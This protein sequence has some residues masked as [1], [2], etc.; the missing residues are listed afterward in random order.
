M[1]TKVLQASDVIK[2]IVIISGL[3]YNLSYAD[4]IIKFKHISLEQG[5]S[6]NSVGCIFQDSKG[7]M[8]FGTRE[9]LNK[10]DG[11]R[12]TNLKFDPGDANS[13]SDDYTFR[14]KAS[15]SDGVWNE[16][17]AA[18]KIIITPPFW[19]TW[20]FRGAAGFA[21]L[22]LIAFIYKAKTNNIRKRNTQLEKRVEERTMELTTANEAL[23]EAHNELEKR[24]DER[25]IELKNANDDFLKA[26]E[27][28]EAANKAKSQF[29]ANMS[30]EIR[31]PMN[32]IIGITQIALDSDL[33]TQQRE[34]FEIVKNSADSLL[35]ILN[36]ILDFS[37]VEIGKLEL[38]EIDFNLNILL[39]GIIKSLEIQAHKKGI[40]LF[41]KISENTPIGLKGDPGRLRQ[42]IINLI[43]NAI[44]FTKEGE[45]AVHVK[46]AKINQDTQFSDENELIDILFSVSDNGIGIPAEKIDDIFKSFTQADN[47]HARKYGGTGLG[48][49]ISYKLVNLMGGN[50][51]VESEVGKG[52]TFYFTV[53]FKP[54]KSLSGKSMNSTK[55]NLGENKRVLIVDD[56]DTNCLIMNKMMGAWG[57]TTVEVETAEHA[58]L[59]LEKSVSQNNRFCLA[60]LDCQMP[61]INGFELAEKMKMNYEW[62]DIKI[63]MMT[64]ASEKGDVARC[65]EIGITS[66]L[67]KPVNQSDLLHTIMV[68]L[69]I[70]SYNESTDNIKQQKVQNSESLNILLAEDNIVNQ[71]IAIKLLQKL[72]HYVTTVNNGK[73]ALAILTTQD[74][75]LVLM[76]IQM[77]EMDGLEATRRIRQPENGC[78]RPDIIIIAMTAHTM[79]G[80]REHCLEVGMN[81]YI[82]KPFEV[83]E[84]IMKIN[85]YAM[86]TV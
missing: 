14:V 60:L 38:E 26:K 44:K 69:R 11:Y 33:S 25:T 66:Y 1:K 50:I 45:I 18:I 57:F 20:W 32:G 39:D 75:D 54:G 27:A 56:N 42:I 78:R 46:P 24:V 9:G 5:L 70:E 3:L 68:A 2:I 7:F 12:F 51:W 13:L 43:M 61:K 84:L 34:N 82:S 15:N 16:V 74:F 72:G 53:R 58:F 8:W 73:E 30:H 86:V 36:D 47:S 6:E 64:S 17:G 67:Q 71:K 41:F 4:H 81:D 76:D 48:L 37:K 83:D 40:H 63:I 59:E 79:K 29:L 80:D 65:K 21:I 23:Q 77:P 28:A 22:C 85:K 55:I 10:Y 52:S 49:T 35:N 62:A 19:Q 31:T